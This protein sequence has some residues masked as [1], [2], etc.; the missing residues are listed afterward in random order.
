P[1]PE[2]LSRRPAVY[3][4]EGGRVTLTG[5]V[6]ATCPCLSFTYFDTPCGLFA[7]ICYI[8]FSM[9]HLSDIP[10]NQPSYSIPD[11]PFPKNPA[12]SVMVCHQ[13]V[14]LFHRVLGHAPSWP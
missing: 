13:A 6:W 8:L 4:T 3:Q 7:A 12:F 10:C 14:G 5:L 9:R 2:R 1:P 11:G